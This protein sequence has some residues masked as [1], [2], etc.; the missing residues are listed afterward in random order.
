MDLRSLGLKK[1]QFLKHDRGRFNGIEKEKKNCGE[2]I[3]KVFEQQPRGKKKSQKSWRRKPLK[4]TILWLF[5]DTI[6]TWV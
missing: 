3:V 2:G 6:K 1:K 5:G 4:H